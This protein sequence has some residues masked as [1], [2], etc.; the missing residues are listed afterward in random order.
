MPN[1]Y[2]YYQRLG[3]DHLIKRG[4]SVKYAEAIG[5]QKCKDQPE[6]PVTQQE[7]LANVPMTPM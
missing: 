7:I 4:K 3:H 2:H 6:K 1:Y 5:A